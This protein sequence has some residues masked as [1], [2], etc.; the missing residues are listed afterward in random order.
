MLLDNSDG[1]GDR[2]LLTQFIGSGFSTGSLP[3][4]ID[5]GG[6]GTVGELPPW[7]GSSGGSGDLIGQIIA[8]AGNIV[9]AVINSLAPKPNVTTISKIEEILKGSPAATAAGGAAAGAG[10]AAL[11]GGNGTK[12]RKTKLQKFQELVAAGVPAK[13]AVAAVGGFHT[14]HGISY[15]QL[16]GFNRVSGLLAHWGMVPRKMHGAKAKRKR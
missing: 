3:G 9:P 12:K 8:A 13:S 1:Y 6:L 11:L 10:V 14:H 16:R 5:I 7:T 4:T 15:A 2:S